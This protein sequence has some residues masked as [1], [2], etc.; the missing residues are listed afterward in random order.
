MKPSLA[1]AFRHAAGAVAFALAC[2]APARAQVGSPRSALYGSE[3]WRF[4]N[5]QRVDS[6]TS[7]NG[8]H[9][10]LSF[11]P[12]G[13]MFRDLVLLK[14]TEVADSGVAAVDLTLNRSFVDDPRNGIF[15]RDIARS[16]LRAA[17]PAADAG[18]IATLAQEIEIP[19]PVSNPSEGYRAYLGSEPFSIQQ[20]PHSMI[21]LLNSKPGVEPSTLRITVM[22]P[23]PP[24]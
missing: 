5:L 17:V 3:F 22:L 21:M 13:A 16:L 6:T 10:E 7:A 23:P 8:R 1:G 18:S 24:R 14:V 15:A 20:F 19:R 9:V 11:R 4:F 12:G 2:A